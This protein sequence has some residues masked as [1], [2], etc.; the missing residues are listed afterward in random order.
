[1]IQDTENI[2]RRWLNGAFIAIHYVLSSNIQKIGIKH[3]PCSQWAVERGVLSGLACLWVRRI[4]PQT[5]KM[6][7]DVYVLGKFMLNDCNFSSGRGDFY[8]L[9]VW[10]WVMTSSSNTS[11]FPGHRNWKEK[12]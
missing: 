2:E 3:G 9:I 8:L 10:Q 12:L 11:M 7:E 1:M 4:Y 5:G 6:G